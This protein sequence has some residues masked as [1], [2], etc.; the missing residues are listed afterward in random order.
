MTQ[1]TPPHATPP[2]AQFKTNAPKN[3]ACKKPM[4]DFIDQRELSQLR[5]YYATKNTEL[6]ALLD[7]DI[8]WIPKL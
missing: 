3:A 6:P 5:E 4:D 7:M 1:R 2:R 8:A